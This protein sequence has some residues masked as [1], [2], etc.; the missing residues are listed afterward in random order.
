MEKHDNRKKDS[1][2]SS[3]IRA[4][5]IWE[6]WDEADEYQ[7][8]EACDVLVFQK[9]YFKKMLEEFQGIKI[10]DICDPDWLDPRP[11]FESISHCDAVT[12]S[13]EPLAE[14]IRKLTN[15]PIVCIPDRLDLKTYPEKKTEHKNKIEEVAWFGYGQNTKCL[16]KTL[17][18]LESKDILLTVISDKPYAP[19]KAYGKTK[20]KNVKYDQNRINEYLIERDAVLL[21]EPEGI[22][23]KFKSNNKTLSA[24][25]LGIPVITEPDDFKRLETKEVR[26]EEARTKLEEVKKDWSIEKSVEQWKEL[27]K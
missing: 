4:R 26:I 16:D 12:T 19:N 18:Q 24:W 6:N 2:G 13:T 22:R 25:A 7:I 20:I 1:V 9:A 10:F 5:W 8:G 11:T 3:R 23:G 14:Y 27:I 15:K 17:T 21:P